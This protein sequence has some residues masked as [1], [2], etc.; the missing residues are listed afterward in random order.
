MSEPKEGARTQLYSYV[1]I[2]KTH[3]RA[4]HAKSRGCGGMPPG[5]FEKLALLKLNLRAFLVI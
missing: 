5:N 2:G 4:R 1:G 3:L